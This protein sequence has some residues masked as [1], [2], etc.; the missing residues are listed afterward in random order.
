MTVSGAPSLDNMLLTKRMSP[1]ELK[2]ELGVDVFP[3]TLL[4]TYHPATLEDNE[5]GRQVDE[6]L[7][8]V[9]ASQRPLLFTMPNSDT[10]GRAIRTRIQQFV[11]DYALAQAVESLGTRAYFSV[12]AICA[13]MV[14]NSSSGLLEAPS[15][16]LPVVNLGARQ[17][18]RTRGQNVIDVADGRG[19]ILA[20][21]TKALD[22][23]FRAALKGTVNPYGDGRAGERIADILIAD[24]TGA[25]RR[26]E[27][28]AG[29]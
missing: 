17:R 16:E 18:G 23:A 13:A 29:R 2:L 24:L 22:P 7:A 25:A 3:D 20:G 5:A 1:E 19:E 15:F 4:V 6:L 27:D 11:Q 14:G 26:T 8:A 28:L 12:L 21:L 9:K 10:G